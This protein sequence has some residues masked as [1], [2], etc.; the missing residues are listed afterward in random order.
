LLNVIDTF[1]KFSWALPIKKKG[2]VTVSKAFEKIIKSANSH[3]HVPPNLLHT[4][5][6]LEFENK[7]FKG[8]LNNYGIN[9]YCTQNLEKLAIVERFNRTLNN[10]MKIL[11]EVRNN[12]KWV[13]ILQNLLDEYNFKDKNRFIGTSPSEVNKLNENLVLRTLF[14]QSKEK[15]K[16]KFEASDRVRIATFKSTFSNKHYPNWTGKFLQLKKYLTQTLQLTKLK[17]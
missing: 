8:L 9:M 15:S 13:D 6:G 2:G 11:F 4:D 7:H 12:K 10:K 14:K 5:K 1:Y 3:N 17:F 16:V